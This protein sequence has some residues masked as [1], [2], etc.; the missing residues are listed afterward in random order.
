VVFCFLAGGVLAAESPPRLL[1]AQIMVLEAQTPE[2]L[3]KLLRQLATAGINCVILRVFQNYNDRPHRLIKPAAASGVY[4]RTKHAPVVADILTP[5]CRTAHKYKLRVF[6]LMTTRSCGWK[7]AEDPSC[8]GYAYDLAS[9]AAVAAYGLNIFSRRV[10]YWLA[11]LYRDLARNDI[12]GIL[13]QDD[14]VLRNTEGVSPEAKAAFFQDTGRRLEPKKLYQGITKYKGRYVAQRYTE[15][16]WS[17]C[18]WKNKKLLDLA[19]MLRRAAKEENP[20]LRFGLNIYYET[21][22]EPENGLAWYSQDLKAAVERRFDYYALMA[23]KRQIEAELG[24]KPEQ[25]LMVLEEM[26]KD[27]L[28]VVGEPQRVWFKL[29]VK[30]W[31]TRKPISPAEIELMLKAATSV[32]P[33]SLAYVPHEGNPPLKIISRYFTR[34]GS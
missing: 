33:V 17:W 8:Q 32:G 24:I 26:A 13:F 6:A 18:R 12:D 30:D 28:Q 7:V 29:Q 19:D 23:Y 16:F 21:V 4:F 1:A 10:R 3:D 14:L 15:L 2:E 31:R 5:F 27:M 20:R 9:D 25:A 34:P 22:V 11:D